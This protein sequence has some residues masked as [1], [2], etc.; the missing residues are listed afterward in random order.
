MVKHWGRE[1]SLVYAR[2]G[3]L[4]KV[5][6]I[7]Y[8]RTQNFHKRKKDEWHS[9]LSSLEMSIRPTIVDAGGFRGDF[10]RQ[11]LDLWPDARVT[12]YEP[13][14]GLASV[15][16]ERFAE[17]NVTVRPFALGAANCTMRMT[18]FGTDAATLETVTKSAGPEVR[19]VDSA[20]EVD[21]WGAIDLLALNVEGSEYA[22]ID[23][24]AHSGRLDKCGAI[25]VQFHRIRNH[26]ILRSISQRQLSVTHECVF[27]VPYLWEIWIRR[28]PKELA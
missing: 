23:R 4:L 17:R 19:V 5:G 14:P 2:V 12:I 6:P 28:S 3:E 15:C 16:Q 10:T 7:Q 24:L 1:C 26:R 9:T 11:C 22:V 21:Q 13:V 8:W 20:G 27:S 18:G 25:A